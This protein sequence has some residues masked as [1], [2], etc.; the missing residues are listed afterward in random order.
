[1]WLRKR[2]Q[3]SEVPDEGGS[4]SL[5]GDMRLLKSAQENG[6]T[7]GPLLDFAAYAPHN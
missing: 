6:L 4:L 5:F 1:M 7:R 3:S 2:P